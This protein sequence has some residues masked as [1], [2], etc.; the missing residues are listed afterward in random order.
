MGDKEYTPG[1]EIDEAILD[2][3]Y[4]ALLEFDVKDPSLPSIQTTN[5]TSSSRYTNHSSYQLN[6]SI[7]RILHCNYQICLLPVAD[8]IFSMIGID[9]KLTMRVSISMGQ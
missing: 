2:L 9:R 4:D 6:L 5:A 8:S 1:Q 7:S 3:N